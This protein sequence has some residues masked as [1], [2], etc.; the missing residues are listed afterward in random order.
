ADRKVGERIPGDRR[1]N[2]YRSQFRP[3]RR[4]TREA[5]RLVAGRQAER[6]VATDAEGQFGVGYVIVGEQI[7]QEIVIMDVSR[8]GATV[9]DAADRIDVRGA[10]E[11]LVAVDLGQGGGIYVYG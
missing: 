3:E 10:A 7:R 8:R 5:I 6:C 4:V 11:N 1:S 2:E 9:F